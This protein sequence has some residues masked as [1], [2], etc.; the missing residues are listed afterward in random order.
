M[1]F[2][3]LCGTDR[4]ITNSIAVG[5]RKSLQHIVG[6]AEKILGVPLTGLSDIYHPQSHQD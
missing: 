2:T 4:F 5:C 3:W 6:T 1:C